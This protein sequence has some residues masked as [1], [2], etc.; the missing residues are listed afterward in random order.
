M[1]RGKGRFLVRLESFKR[2]GVSG[3]VYSIVF[4]WIEN[5]FATALL[6]HRRLGAECALDGPHVGGLQTHQ[7]LDIQSSV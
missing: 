6:S 3:S 1:R 7:K 2:K 5:F 4:A